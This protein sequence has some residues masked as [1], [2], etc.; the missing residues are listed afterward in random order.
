MTPVHWKRGQHEGV[1]FSVDE[2]RTVVAKGKG[3]KAVGFDLTSYELVKELCRNETS[4][5]ALL[6]W[7]EAVR[8]GAEIPKAW[9]TTIIT[10]L[11]KKPK[12]AAPSDMRPI[13]LSSALGKIFGGLLL[14]RTRAVLHPRGPV[15]SGPSRSRQNGSSA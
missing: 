4:E 13:S 3:R 10:L 15:S 12:P 7:M 2:L 6:A 11:H 9:L 5:Q 1:P 8:M 14:Q